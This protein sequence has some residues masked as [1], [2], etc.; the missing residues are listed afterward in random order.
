MATGSDLL[1]RR[2]TGLELR[3]TLYVE[4]LRLKAEC[5][6]RAIEEMFLADGGPAYPREGTPASQ[7]RIL[8]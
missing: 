6:I 3:I 4:A 1:R 7:R 2:L 5:S 8:P